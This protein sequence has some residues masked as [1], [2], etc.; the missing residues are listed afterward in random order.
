MKGRQSECA[1]QLTIHVDPVLPL[2]PPLRHDGDGLWYGWRGLISSRGYIRWVD[3]G[4][5]GEGG[6]VGLMWVVD[7]MGEQFYDGQGRAGEG[8]C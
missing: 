3:S 7:R 1:E 6:D 4:E 5:E 2:L 8:G